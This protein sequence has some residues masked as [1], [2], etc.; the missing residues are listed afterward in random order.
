ML[1]N[2]IQIA[3]SRDQLDVADISDI[4]GVQNVKLANQL[5]RLRRAQ[6]LAKDQEMQQQN[7][8]AQAK[9]NSESAMAAEQAKA[10]AEQI[11]AQS[12]IQ[13]EQAKGQIDLGKLEAEKQAKMELMLYEFELNTQMQEA[14]MAEARY[15]QREKIGGELQKEEMKQTQKFESSGNDIIS[16]GIPT[17]NFEPS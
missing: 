2:N 1:E 15:S 9:A 16:G 8:E 17:N 7:I 5:L 10:Q 13:I 6:K 4:R 11:I 14:Q 12:K 3:I